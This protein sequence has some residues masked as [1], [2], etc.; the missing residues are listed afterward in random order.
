MTLAD[1]AELFH[2]PDDQAFATFPVGDHRENWP[3]RSRGF[4]G[5]LS[6]RFYQTTG[7]AP[8]NQILQDCLN[9]VE[10]KARY[11]GTREK[12][13]V[14]VGTN[15]DD[16]LF[17]DLA[18]EKWEAVEITPSGWRIVRD[19]PVKF[20]RPAGLL[21][22][23]T[24]ISRP[25]TGFTAFRNLTNLGDET[26]VLLVSWLVG[27]LQPEGPYPIL[28]LQGEQGSGKST[29]AR[30]LKEIID[31]SAGGLRTIPRNEQDLIIGAS[32]S[33]ITSYDNISSVH[34]WLSDGFCR[35]ATG[36]ALATRELYSDRN[37]IILDVKRP[38]IFNGIDSL[39]TRHDLADRAILVHLPFIQNSKRR[40]EKEIWGEFK[41]AVPLILPDL[42][43]AA[44]C[45]LRNIANV[46]LNNLPR[47]ADFAEWVTAAEP[48]LP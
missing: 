25:G 44:A 17:F 47:M 21:P 38:L 14:R 40:T 7:K 29:A 18:N 39:A 28:V 34:P 46:R 30:I 16:A 45:A 13:Y 15:R 33:W 23:P 1:E 12:N 48:S 10:A 42:P 8:G 32:N 20:T 22:L 35:L 26:F 36:G 6:R 5:W 43:D 3:V 27:A 4:R 24:P 19:P 31:P 9:V 11:D 37:E 2:S 41:K